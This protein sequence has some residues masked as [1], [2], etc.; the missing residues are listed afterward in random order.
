MSLPITLRAVIGNVMCMNSLQNICL[1][2]SPRY[3]YPSVVWDFFRACGQSDTIPN[4]LL[5]LMVN[6][7]VRVV[8]GL[9]KC[10]RRS[11][12]YP[13]RQT[14]ALNAALSFGAADNRSV[15][16]QIEII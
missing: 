2:L 13:V 12:N 3:S 11:C 15:L 5:I 6:Y 7:G 16:V 9:F 1:I 10:V 4:L 14:D 8:F